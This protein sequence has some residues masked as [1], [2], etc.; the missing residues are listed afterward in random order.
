M[1]KVAIHEESR[2][3]C[4]LHMNCKITTRLNEKKKAKSDDVSNT[5]DGEN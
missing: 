5:S 4:A 2:M 1:A 3:C